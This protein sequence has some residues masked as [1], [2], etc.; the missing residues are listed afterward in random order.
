LSARGISERREGLAARVGIGAWLPYVLTAVLIWLGWQ[1]VV[2]LLVQR[3]P[4]ETAIRVAPG[5][6]LVLS[7]AAESELVADRPEQALELASLALGRS[8]FDVRALRVFGLA[9][10]P[11]DP[12]AA[13]QILTLAGNWSLRDDPAHAWLIDRRLR[14]GDYVGAFGHADVL[15]RRRPDL[16]PT[17]FSLFTT[18]AAT[19]PRAMRPLAAR[20]AAQPGW[21]ADYLENLRRDPQ[22]PPVQA[23][24]ALLLQETTAPLTDDELGAIYGDWLDEGRLPGLAALR[25]RLARPAPATVHDGD[26]RGV[27]APRPYGWML[28]SGSG[29]TTAVSALP[30]TPEESALLVQTDAFSSNA[31]ATQLIHLRPGRHALGVSWKFEAGGQAPSM[32][33]VVICVETRQPIATFRPRSAQP[34]SEWARTITPFDVPASRCTAQFLQLQTLTGTR[35][36][37]V[38]AWFD[39]VRLEVGTPSGGAR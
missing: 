22:A 6:A 38:I 9:T 36:G 26:F 34:A 14:Q 8:P 33:W 28:G 37:S 27:A 5:S 21:R 3:A 10:A 12:A 15:A 29:L 32:E 13:D 20:V 7:R 31:V 39:K 1:V 23:G 30:D 25:S 35:R 16:H 11:G 17:L 24:L 4:V 19:D 2:A 18:A